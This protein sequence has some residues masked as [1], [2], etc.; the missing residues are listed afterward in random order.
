MKTLALI[1]LTAVLGGAFPAQ[2]QARDYTIDPT[3][4]CFFLNRAEN[5]P[6]KGLKIDLR[7]NTV[8]ELSLRGDAYF[9]DQRGA[10]ADP[11]PG[12]VIFYSTNQEDGFDSEY[13]VLRKGERL[14]FTTPANDPDSVFLIAFVLDHW[15][16]SKNTGSLT[17]SVQ[18]R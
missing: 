4:N 1:I 12:V 18:E 5:L 2:S 17:L 6:Q 9:S 10:A 11:M 16:Q 7:M 13:T 8:Y 3:K 14:T 15:P